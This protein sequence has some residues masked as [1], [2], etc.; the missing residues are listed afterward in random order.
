MRGLVYALVVIAGLNA[1]AVRADALSPS[2]FTAQFA[3]ALQAAMPSVQV[4]VVRDLQLDIKR[5]DGTAA[6][7]NL[8]NNYRDYSTDPKWFD[9]VIKAYATALAKPPAVKH[10]AKLDSTRIVPVIKDRAWLA[11]LQGHYKKLASSQQP[12]FDE[13]NRELVVVYAEDTAGTTRYLSSSESL[14]VERGK[15][16]ALAIDNVMRLMPRI[17]MRQGEDGL[18]M[19]TSHAD[20]GASLL[21]VDGIWSGGQIKVD[22][23]IVVAV[24]AKDVILITGSRDRKG[25]KAMRTAAHNLAKGGYGLID[26]L[27]VYRKR[28]FVKF[29]RD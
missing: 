6:T 16:R 26:T 18:A 29:G 12:V 24:P 5:A 8:A 3:R 23:D 22:G 10:A 14:G 2:A 17:E 20:Y 27:F 9:D 21:L 19:M 28:R 13:F 4:S 7:V 11:E 25:L 15:L 1:A